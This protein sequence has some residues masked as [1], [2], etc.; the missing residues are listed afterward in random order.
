MNEEEF[1]QLLDTLLDGDLSPEE[2]AAMESAIYENPDFQRLYLEA[3]KTHASLAWPRRWPVTDFASLPEPSSPIAL[4]RKTKRSL[5]LAVLACA[6]A[7]VLFLIVHQM[8][9]SSKQGLS[10]NDQRA[11]VATTP[12]KRSDVA[13]SQQPMDSD[14]QSRETNRSLVGVISNTANVEWRNGLSRSTGSAL[15]QGWLRIDSGM[16]Q[17]DF[18]GGARL[19][20]RGPAELHLRSSSE[21]LLRSGEVTCYVGELGRGF[22]LLTGDSEVIDLGTSFGMRVFPNEKAE[23]HV[24]EGKVAIRQKSEDIPIEFSE[25][26]AVRFDSDRL[27][28]VEYSE[29]RFPGY[30][31]LQSERALKSQQ[32]YE[33][34]KMYAEKLSNDPSVLVYYTFED[35]RAD[36]IEVLNRSKS[37]MIGSQGAILGAA[38]DEGRWPSKAGLRFRDRND[39]VLFRVPGQHESVTF[40]VWARLDALMGE[41][42]ALLM[43]EYPSRWILNGSMQSSELAETAAL[44]ANAPVKMCRWTLDSVG[45]P[46]FNVGFEQ[47]PTSTIEWDSY[48]SPNSVAKRR[49]WGHWACLAVTYDTVSKKIVH[50]Q[51]GKP[52][53][54]MDIDRPEPLF[55]QCME[56]GNLSTPT[57]RTRSDVDFRFYGAID[58]VMIAKRAFKAHEI[59]EIYEVGNNLQ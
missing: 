48:V 11:E 20:V 57:I 56:L 21:A 55:L 46:T 26:S 50:Y 33:T 6:A 27:S 43:S 59:A 1:R 3:M 19:V 12:D 10:K 35:Q 7:S 9:S 47:H 36:D 2:G 32:K 16:I 4:K 13:V 17:I 28:P 41:R 18:F 38:W 54:S 58:E 15:R 22:R 42:T 34:W 29:S 23:V 51:N 53:Q 52:I 14:R 31:D 5:Q 40:L 44:H 37:K 24:F 45:R 39:R 49:D 25:K 8:Q 30:Q